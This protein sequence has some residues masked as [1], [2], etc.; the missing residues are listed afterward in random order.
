MKCARVKD[1]MTDY[2][3]GEVSEVLRKEIEG[4]LETCPDCRSTERSLRAA[5][6]PLRGAK[7]FDAPEEVWQRIKETIGRE[8]ET[9]AHPFPASEWTALLRIR[10]PALV[11]AAAMVFICITALVFE[12]TIVIRKIAESYVEEG[13]LFLSQLEKDAPEG[14]WDS[15][16]RGL[17]TSIEKYLL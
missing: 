12:K 5:I 17:G 2:I 11:L 1:L 6:E 3:D 4:H 15:E 9:R 13:A 8:S 10:R 14:D 16:E 7:K